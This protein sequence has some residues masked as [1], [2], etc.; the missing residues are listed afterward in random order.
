MIVGEGVRIAVLGTLIGVAGAMV[1]T[2]FLTRWLYGVT[3]IDPS[4]FASLSL[5]MVA[6][7]VLACWIPARWAAAIDPVESL[8]Y[9]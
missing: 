5:V 8:R 7:A 6:V 4:V 3:A 2:R 9:E 1:A